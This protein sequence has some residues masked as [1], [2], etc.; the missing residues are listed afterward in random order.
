[1]QLAVGIAMERTK[2]SFFPI[3]HT[4]KRKKEGLDSSS[5]KKRLG[6]DEILKDMRGTLR[7]G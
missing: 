5:K 3:P 1:M 2:G 4:F 6:T 7:V